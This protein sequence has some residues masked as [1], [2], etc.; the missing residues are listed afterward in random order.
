[1]KQNSFADYWAQLVKDT[2]HHTD[3]KQTKGRAAK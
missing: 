2:P 3:K 1:M